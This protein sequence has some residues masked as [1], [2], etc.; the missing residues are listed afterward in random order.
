MILNAKFLG[1]AFVG[2]VATALVSVFASVSDQIA[3]IG[4][5]ASSV[6]GLML[7]YFDY[8][9]ARDRHTAILLGELNLPRELVVHGGFMA[10]YRRIA[11]SLSVLAGSGQST[12][13][14]LAL[15]QLSALN[16]KIGEMANGRFVY[17]RTETWRTVYEQLLRKPEVTKYRSVAWFRTADYW[18]D[19]PGKQSLEL[20]CQLVENDGLTIH[21]TVIV[22]DAL[23]P[24]DQTLPGS[25]VREWIERQH[26]HGIWIRLIRESALRDEPGLLMDFGLYGDE[27]VGFQI[28]DD[29]GR[30]LRFELDFS[31]GERTKANALWDRLKLFATSY[32]DLLDQNQDSD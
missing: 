13:Q 14:D 3:V 2:S 5:L 32:A 29:R 8:V 31:E 11:A 25:P 30:T 26:I 1:V 20:N 21:R 17:E 23:W 6:F 7:S 4:V 9:Q 15:A 27:A 10:V 18:Q 19:I 12:V 22:A 24:D 16:A 28:L